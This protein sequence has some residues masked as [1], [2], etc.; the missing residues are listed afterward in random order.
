MKRLRTRGP[1]H[2][3][4]DVSLWVP[5]IQYPPPNLSPWALGRFENVFSVL[6]YFIF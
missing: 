5:D 2:S 1:A 6:S 4:A 3:H